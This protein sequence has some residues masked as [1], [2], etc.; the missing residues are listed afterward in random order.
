[1]TGAKLIYIL[2][3][4]MACAWGV[5]FI[6]KWRAVRRVW[7]NTARSDD[8]PRAVIWFVAAS[9]EIGALRWLCF[10]NAVQTMGGTEIFWWAGVYALNIAGACAVSWVYWERHSA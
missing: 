5:P 4:L 3:C 1:M 10:P 9:M 6:R 2:Q 7:S 8:L